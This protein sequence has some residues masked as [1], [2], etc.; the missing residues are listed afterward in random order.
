MHKPK[1][2]TVLPLSSVP[3]LYAELPVK[4]IK[5]LGGKFG[6]LVHELLGARTMG[7]VSKYTLK[8][9]QN[10]FGDKSGYV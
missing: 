4:N 5:K 7:D 3:A 9:L 6:D 10:K 8:E 1:C 2:Q